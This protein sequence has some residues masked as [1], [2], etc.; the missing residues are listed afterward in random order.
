MWLPERRKA[1]RQHEAS[2]LARRD[3]QQ[4][5]AALVRRGLRDGSEE[6]ALGEA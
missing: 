5:L 3:S 4:G 1:W 2:I 6:I